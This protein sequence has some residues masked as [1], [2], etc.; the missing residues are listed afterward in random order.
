[1]FS[2]SVIRADYSSSLAPEME[3][4]VLPLNLS[5]PRFMDLLAS[6]PFLHM[7]SLGSHIY[8]TQL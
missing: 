2:T 1:M 5:L 8:D 4:A 6:T 3:G 7:L